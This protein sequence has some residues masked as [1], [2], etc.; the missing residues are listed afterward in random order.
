VS[1]V[2]KIVQ[3]RQGAKLVGVAVKGRICPRRTEQLAY[4]AGRLIGKRLPDL[5]LVTGGLGGAMTAA[6][7]GCRDVCGL[8]IG[9]TPAASDR[10]EGIVA[11]SDITID[12]G[13]TTLAR[14]VIF[15]SCVD[16]LVAVPGSHGTRQEIGMAVDLDKP[17]WC[18][19]E[20]EHELAGATYFP[21]LAELERD[22]DE[23]VA[24]AHADRLVV[25]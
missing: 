23:L 7:R 2:I 22:L 21:D 24:Q 9:L 1:A 18:I 8:S 17:V 11:P 12:T 25:S 16:V 5:V 19:G 15:A 14:N 4:D 6:A 10:S 3:L 13:M 20:H